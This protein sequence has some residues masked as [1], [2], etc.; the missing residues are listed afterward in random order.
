MPAYD[1]DF[2]VS[3]T[4]ADREWAEWISWA[5]EEAGYRILVQAWDFVPGANWVNEMQKGVT[6]AARVLAVLS[7]D[8]LENSKFGTAEWQAF[9]RGDPDGEKRRVLPVRVER[10]APEGLLGGIVYIDLVGLAKEEAEKI[11]IDRVRAS[12]AGRVRPTT[13]PRFP[14]R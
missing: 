14:G 6:K 13:P 3:Y 8:Y 2:F 5:L 10:C 7:P 11:L 12:L 1:Y 4:G 9:W